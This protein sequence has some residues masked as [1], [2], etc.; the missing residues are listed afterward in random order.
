MRVLLGLEAVNE[1]LERLPP[2]EGWLGDEERARLAAMRHPQRRAQFLAGHALARDLLARAEGGDW[3]DWRLERDAQGAPCA[4]RRGA[5]SGLRISLAH[6]AGQVAGAVAEVPVGVDLEHAPRERDLLALAEALY[7]QEFSQW[8]AALDE[9][10]R[11]TH[12]Y[13]RW[14]LDE[15]HGKA[16]GVGLQPKALVRQ[17]WLP[18]VEDAPHAWTWDIADGWLALA[19]GEPHAAP[20]RIEAPPL[21]DP[22]IPQAWSLRLVP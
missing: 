7:P 16:L 19:L 11:R 8:L 5:V 18:A 4:L 17:A 20:P 21:H 13:R 15:A 10:R 1:V 12:F 2:G 22:S 9:A 3:R 6:S 14:T